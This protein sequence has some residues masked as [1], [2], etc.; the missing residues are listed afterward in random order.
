MVERRADP[1]DR[2]VRRLHLLPAATPILTEIARYRTG[3]YAE[4]TDGLDE[5]TLENLVDGLLH[6]KTKLTAEPAGGARLAVAGE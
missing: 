2:R 1:S 6:I 5:A 4:I 3:M